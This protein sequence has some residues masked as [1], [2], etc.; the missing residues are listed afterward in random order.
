[1][2]DRVMGWLWGAPLGYRAFTRLDTLLA[3]L[4]S[5]FAVLLVSGANKHGD[6][7]G[8]VLACAAVL[9]MTAPVAWRRAHPLGAVATLATGALFNAIVV[10]TF[11]RCGGTLPAL[12]LVVYSVGARCQLRPAAL[13]AVLAVVSMVTQAHSDPNLKG[14]SV[15]GSV[16][17]LALWGVGRLVRSREDMVAA[18]RARTAELRD[19]RDRTARLAVAADRARVA[20]DLDGKLGER[21]GELASQAALARD[22]IGREPDAARESLTAIEQQG[23]QALTDMREIV[24]ALRDEPQSGPQPSLADLEPLLRR[25]LAIPARLTIDGDRC[26]LPAGVELSAFRIVER[27]LETLDAAA[28]ERVHVTVRYEPD[29][30]EVA[31]RGR[32]RAGSD[33][34]TTLA[35]AREWVSLHAGT[36]ESQLRS[37]VSQTDVRLPLVT[38]HA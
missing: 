24:G 8:G 16:L 29:A 37:G 15:G 32:V 12:A 5:A 6:P 10:G 22:A 28:V 18:L 1:M 13:G 27:L 7:H 2:V 30:L 11:V 38:A 14:F 19:Q 23:R 25:T 21:I 4:L 34:Q 17:I 26:A 31:V 35:T 20:A 3:L 36:L 9:L 33:L